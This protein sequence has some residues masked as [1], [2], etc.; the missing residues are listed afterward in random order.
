M[1]QMFFFLFKNIKRLTQNKVELGLNTV[2]SM[3]YVCDHWI[4]MFFFF[5]NITIIILGRILSLPCKMRRGPNNF[6]KSHQLYD[7][8]EVIG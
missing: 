3:F 4:L 5:L 7:I 1:R 6:L 8:I 2:I